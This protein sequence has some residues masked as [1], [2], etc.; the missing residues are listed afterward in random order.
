[1]EDKDFLDD[2]VEI[3]IENTQNS[4]RKEEAISYSNTN[5]NTYNFFDIIFSKKFL[6]LTLSIISLILLFFMKFLAICGVVSP[7]FYG[8]FFF[9]SAG[10]ALTATILIVIK[11][12]KNKKIEF[13]I[14]VFFNILSL[15]FLILF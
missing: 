9:L 12:V 15:I 10:I 6:P 1:M 7:A 11:F 13:D 3:K 14:P 5:V 4:I 2:N 8:I